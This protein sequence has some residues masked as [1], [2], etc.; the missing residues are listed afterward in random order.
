M[1]VKWK[2]AQ[3]SSFYDLRENTNTGDL[4]ATH[5]PC[6]GLIWPTWSSKNKAFY[7]NIHIF[8]FS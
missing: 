5:S 7:K 3:D 8:V 4:W 1:Y 2:T 6:N